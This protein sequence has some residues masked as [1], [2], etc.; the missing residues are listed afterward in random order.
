M[1]D[2]AAGCRLDIAAQRGLEDLYDSKDF[3]ASAY[4]TGLLS[5]NLKWVVIM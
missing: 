4:M 5:R 2:S 3:A 1:E